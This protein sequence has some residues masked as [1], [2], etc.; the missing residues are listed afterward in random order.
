MECHPFE[1]FAR[2]A[3]LDWLCCMETANNAR[4]FVGGILARLSDPFCGFVPFLY[5]D[6]QNSAD[7]RTVPHG[8]LSICDSALTHT[9]RVSP[10]RETNPKS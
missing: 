5:R 4:R 10:P 2:L 6:P 3:G 7:A 8:S 9:A 1:G